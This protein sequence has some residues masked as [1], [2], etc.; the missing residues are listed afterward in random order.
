MKEYRRVPLAQL[1]KR[2]KVEEYEAETPFAAMEHRPK[3]VRI[4]LSQHAGKPATPVVKPGDRVDAG[5]PV[6][7]VDPKDLG[8]DV[9]SSISGTVEA[10]TGAYVEIRA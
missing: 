8:V 10:V 5:T 7:R 2:L 1:R 4:K 3:A 6:G 9:H